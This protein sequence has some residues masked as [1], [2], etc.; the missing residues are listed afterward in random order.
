MTRDEAYTLVCKAWVINDY[1][2]SAEIGP[3]GLLDM[4][5]ALGV[6]KLDEPKTVEAPIIP[7]PEVLWEGQW[8]TLREAM[9]RRWSK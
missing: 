8:I 9:A 6:L 1:T 5:V 3:R 7:E 4:L 2:H